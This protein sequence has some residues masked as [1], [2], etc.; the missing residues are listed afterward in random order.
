MATTRP[1]APTSRASGRLCAPILAPMSSTSAPGLIQ[2]AARRG[3]L[4]EPEIDRKIDA[5]IEIEVPGHLAAANGHAR[6]SAGDRARADDRDVEDA[7]DRHLLPGRQ[8]RPM[9]IDSECG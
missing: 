4:I 9:A 3:T 5:L 7:G 1:S 8:H 6:R 2:R